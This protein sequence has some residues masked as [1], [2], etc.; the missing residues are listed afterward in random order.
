MSSIRKKVGKDHTKLVDRY[1]EGVFSPVMEIYLED[2]QAKPALIAEIVGRP[3][4]ANE[5]PFFIAAFVVGRISVNDSRF[6]TNAGIGVGSSLGEI[7]RIYKVNWIA[8]GEGPLVARVD[9]MGMSFALDYATPPK[10][11]F[12][13]HDPALIPDSARAVSILLTDVEAVR[14]QPPPSN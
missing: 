10:E 9:E 1:S 7:R 13:T 14:S 4:A 8:F 11:W 2:K 6:K 5:K 3:P 12:A